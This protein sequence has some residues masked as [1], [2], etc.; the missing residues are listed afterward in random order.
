MIT[1][2]F[3]IPPRGAQFRHPFVFI[4]DMGANKRFEKMGI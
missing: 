1:G 3:W 4:L 2:I